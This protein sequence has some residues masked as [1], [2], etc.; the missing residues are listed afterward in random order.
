[1]TTPTNASSTLRRA[2]AG[3]TLAYTNG[4]YLTGDTSTQAVFQ[5]DAS[6]RLTWLWANEYYLTVTAGTN[7]T[8]TTGADGWYTNGATVT[9]SATGNTGY[10]FLQWSGNVPAGSQTSN[11]LTLALDQP[12]TIQ[13]N[14]TP[15]VPA[16]ET[17]VWTGTGRWTS[18]TNWSPAGLPGPEDTVAIRSGSVI[19][20][21][22]TTVA[23]LV[24]SNGA[25][26]IFTNW[27]S[28]LGTAGDIV[29][30]SGATVTL[31]SAFTDVQMSNNVYF[32]CSNF[33]LETGGTINADYAG[34]QG[35]FN[36]AGY[37]PGSTTQDRGG[38]GHG[39][40]GTTHVAG[41]WGGDAYGS[42]N[43]PVM[44]GSGG[45]GSS[46]GT[47]GKGGGAVRI[48]ASGSIC[49]NGIISAN[50]SYTNSVG[51]TGGG[52]GGS[53][54]LTCAT[55]AG[56]NGFVR[57]NGGTGSN[58]GGGGGRI[59]IICTD[60]TA[61]AQLP[62]PTV[63]FSAMRGGG[64]MSPE[65]GTVYLS[66]DLLIPITMTNF[67]GRL[68]GLPSWT[69][70]FAQL[71]MAS[72]TILLPDDVAAVALAVTN[73]LLL[74]G[75][76]LD[77]DGY[78]AS[79]TPMT[80]NVGGNLTLTNAAKLYVYAGVTNGLTVT[81]GGW[82]GVTGNVSIATNCILY[83]TCHA[84]N[85]GAVRIVANNVT[86]DAGGSISADSRGYATGYGPGKPSGRGGAGHGGPGGTAGGTEYGGPSYG[87]SNAP[88]EPGSGSNQRNGGGT[89]WINAGGTIRVN[90]TL[91]A[92]G[93]DGA[94]DNG[95][96][97][98]GSIYLT[99]ATIAGASG[100]F[101]NV[102]GGSAI[103]T[104]GGGGGGRIAVN[105]GSDQMGTNNVTASG[106]VHTTVPSRN[107]TNG[108]VV[109]AQ[110]AS[111]TYNLNVSGSP[112]PHGVSAP[113]D[114]GNNAVAQGSDV[115]L[116]VNT[117]ADSANGV[118][119]ACIG[120]T[121][122]N[123]TGVVDSGTSNAAS[124]LL[125]TNLFLTWRWTSEWYLATSANSNGVLQADRTGWHT[126]GTLVP[127]RANADS[128]YGFLQWSGMGV[129]AG[130]HT[131]SPLTFTMDRPRTLVAQFATTTPPSVRTWTG[132]GEWWS[133]T[134]WTPAGVPGRTE[135]VAISSGTTT[136]RDPIAVAGV[137]V[138]NTGTLRV[139]STA[140][141]TVASS[142]VI[143]GASAVVVVS[144]AMLTCSNG[145]TV[146]GGGKLYAWGGV[147]D[148]PTN[149]ACIITAMGTLLVQSNSFVFP[150][151]HPTNGG[152]AFFRVGNLTVEQGGWVNADSN[153]FAGTYG[154]GAPGGGRGGGG[155]GGVGGDGDPGIEI[156]GG[157]Y[158]WSNAPVQPGSGSGPGYGDTR[159][160]G[161]VVWVLADRVVTVDGVVSANGSA[162]RND[163]GAG[164]GGSIYIR[165]RSF[166]GSGLYEARGGDTSG[167]SGGGGGGRIAIYR[168]TDTFTGTLSTNS[169]RG[170]TNATYYPARGGLYGTLV[171]EKSPAPGTVFLFR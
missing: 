91:T 94:N 86:L 170:G 84:T 113:H 103:L 92:K 168:V 69:L 2:C 130:Q 10:A 105:F 164:A 100:G 63:N 81:N 20:D 111:G 74:D 120:W 57:A 122:S 48:E 135:S 145:L 112:A 141:L 89:V 131:V 54:Y 115:S 15:A 87:S 171:L 19:L 25:T 125:S 118:R 29:I 154:P 75:S 36:R 66:T 143:T 72:S 161:G 169:V 165:C 3:W 33:T 97:A 148:N 68:R 127:L 4:T 155:Y 124:F 150:C 42:T 1:M 62:R 109:W 95:A 40:R 6:K 80:L 132:S 79:R 107:G 160:G 45:S 93:A 24:I 73:D 77:V 158:G 65:L 159:P 101:M 163:S 18:W 102:N 59:A 166:H 149:P 43:A 151:S 37:G 156:G 14:F 133:V 85:G 129:P 41:T 70:N 78:A 136:L 134:N 142:M 52:S 147:T 64:A 96:G 71:A 152:S 8:A 23:S 27:N 9:L 56:T 44:P 49:V 119:Y 138:S 28:V 116:S 13:A 39:G 11:P 126:N 30:S 22:P 137:T 106:G 53:I 108:T 46:G 38:A 67:N 140:T 162:G 99:C 123:G 104:S 83:S 50:A 110:V 7:G 12:R 5:L 16:A 58:G 21:G 146:A 167:T 121:L 98:G 26:L 114:Y 76:T 157:T 117:P 61:Q 17:K 144:N 34:F 32:S 51:N 35:G 55:F 47:G 60:D 153:G 90:G 139:E 31:A 88:I 82:L 128:G